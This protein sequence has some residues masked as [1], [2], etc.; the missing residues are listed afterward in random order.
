M[1]L[2]QKGLLAFGAVILIAVITVALITGYSTEAAFR[3]YAVLYSGRTAMTAEALI[4]YHQTQGGWAGLQEALPE[5]AL[6]RR[7]RGY[8]SGM[9]TSA[10][11][12]LGYRV[13]DAQQSVI[14]DSDGVPEGRLSGAEVAA[15]LPLTVA[16]TTIG[17]LVPDQ[18]TGAVTLDAPANAYLTRLR[19]ALVLGGAAAAIAA[20]LI[21]GILTR[22]IVSPV[23]SLTRTAEVIAQ[24]KLDARADVQGNDEIARLAVTFNQM[25]A[26]LEQA[27]A[28]RRAQTADIA[29]ELRN[30]LAVLQSSLE[31]LADQVYDPTPENIEPALDQVRT[32]NRLVED[33]RT[34]ALAD[35]G[36]LR[37]DL[38]ML[39][40]RAA[41]A[42]AVDAHRDALAEKGIE[43]IGPSAGAALPPLYADYT[44]LAQV[45][46]NILGNAVRHLPEGCTVRVTLVAEEGGAT[47]C[48]ADNGPGLPEED[49]P[50]LFDRFWRREPSR[51]RDSGGSGLGLA[52]AQQIIQA[53]G[54]RIWAGPT[55]GGGLTVCFWLPAA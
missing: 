52:I 42:R 3:R 17:Y 39:D 19:W 34:L 15:A 24:G 54:G 23:R 48:F 49:L 16:G 25:A 13:A 47:A 43:I 2:Y 32:L 31:A 38:Q 50:R 1:N 6:P 21:A 30:P 41:V 36:R 18:H 10:E 40:L 46:N 7:G 20:F 55:P 14:A 37:L 51:S 35:A 33:L 28:A 27:E 11:Q 22:G 9:G 8:G 26:S 4:A 44:R 53:H 12:P 45:L 5:L 29:H